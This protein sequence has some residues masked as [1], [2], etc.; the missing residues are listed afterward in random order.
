MNWK[1]RNEEGTKIHLRYDNN[2]LWISIFWRYLY[3][4]DK[5]NNRKVVGIINHI[6]SA[7]PPF[8]YLSRRLP[9]SILSQS[10][11]L[12]VF[13]KKIYRHKMPLPFYPLLL[14]FLLSGLKIT[15]KFSESLF[16]F[17]D[18][19]PSIGITISAFRIDQMNPQHKKK[20]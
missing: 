15:L 2:I 8:R 6:I 9:S 13:S 7:L 17:S 11:G 1:S 14:F 12:I 10:E 19:L 20:R 18:I 4:T 5:K 3:H 16:L